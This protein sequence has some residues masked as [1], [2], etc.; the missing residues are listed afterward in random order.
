M[1]MQMHTVFYGA[2]CMAV[3]SV[4]PTYCFADVRSVVNELR[5]GG[6]TSRSKLPPVQTDKRLQ[7]AA[8]RIAAGSTTENATQ[9]MAYPTMQ[10]STINLTGYTSDDAVR[11]LLKQRYCSM[12]LQPEWRDIAS[13]Q[14]GD[15]LW[16]VLAVPHAMPTDSRTMAREVLALVNEARAASRRC[17]AERY[18]A[19][20]PL[21]LNTLLNKS[22]QLHAADMAQH[23]KMQH[24]G[25]DGSTPAQRITRQGYRWKAVGENVAAGAGSAAEVV[26]G[27]LNSPGHCANIMNTTF[28]EMG[29][30]YSINQ[31]DGYAV[32]WAQSFATPR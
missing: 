6:C 4:I 26:S 25:S 1:R 9:A 7:A 10:V 28:I 21:R 5:D 16:I 23:Q 31:H 32:Y 20:A 24:E 30:A 18:A 8:K 11:Q 27:W 15:S 19:V 2:L 14:R 17:G 22:A 13:E 29:I 12:L 3:N